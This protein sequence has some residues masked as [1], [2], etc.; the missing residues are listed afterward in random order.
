MSASVNSIQAHTPPTPPHRS[1]EEV[2]RAAVERSKQSEAVVV[3]AAKAERAHNR[4]VG[5]VV[6]VTA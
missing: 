5:S 1:R 3:Q 6:D 4:G 2:T